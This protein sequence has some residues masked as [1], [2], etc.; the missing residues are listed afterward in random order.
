V[1]KVEHLG[2]VTHGA[3]LKD[4]R[5]DDFALIFGEPRDEFADLS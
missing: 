3:L 1:H 2:N 5:L 4:E